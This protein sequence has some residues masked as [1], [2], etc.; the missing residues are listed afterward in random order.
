MA[1]LCAALASL[2]NERHK[3]G[4]DDKY[5]YQD[6]DFLRRWVT[7]AL[8]AAGHIRNTP[9]LQNMASKLIQIRWI[10]PEQVSAP[11]HAS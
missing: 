6:L 10:E 2:A 7:L 9:G 8:E 1:H 11:P 3:E 5:D 4:R